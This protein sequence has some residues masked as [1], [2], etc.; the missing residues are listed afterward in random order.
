MHIH[1]RK[2]ICT[3][4]TPVTTSE[5]TIW[6]KAYV[7]TAEQNQ[8]SPI[9]TPLY[10]EL[11]DQLGN[12]S[13]RQI[14]QLRDGEGEGQ[15]I[16]TKALFSGFG[17]IRAYTKWMLAFSEKQYFSRTIPVYIENGEGS[18]RKP[19]HHHLPNG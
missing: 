3:W 17:E 10:V 11:L 9:S 5:T 13:D 7:V 16:L 14:I 12:T 1:A 6:Y 2:P 8:P 19:E 4:T 18:R 15:F